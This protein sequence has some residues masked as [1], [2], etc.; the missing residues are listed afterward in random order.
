MD[1]VKLTIYTS[2]N[3]SF[4]INGTQEEYDV[5]EK[6]LDKL[7]GKDAMVE[8]TNQKL[9]IYAKSIVAYQLE[10]N[11][12][13]TEIDRLMAVSHEID[14]LIAKIRCNTDYEHNKQINDILLLAEEIKN[15]ICNP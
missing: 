6:Q 8:F 12:K 1:K 11:N 10:H 4:K 9:K 7:I 14:T 15:I 5:I 2:D 3:N 13:T